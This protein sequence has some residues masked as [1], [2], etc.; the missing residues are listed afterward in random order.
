MDKKVL[1]LSKLQIRE[2][3]V[4]ERWLKIHK[5]KVWTRKYLLEK[6]EENAC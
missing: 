3:F 4:S 5:L 1:S 6:G 2:F